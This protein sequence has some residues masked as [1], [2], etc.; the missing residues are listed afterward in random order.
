MSGNGDPVGGIRLRSTRIDLIQLR[1]CHFVATRLN[2][3][4]RSGGREFH[5]PSRSSSAY[6]KRS[7]ARGLGANGGSSPL[8]EACVERDESV[9]DAAPTFAES[10]AEEDPCRSPQRCA[11][12]GDYRRPNI[13]ATNLVVQGLN[14]DLGAGATRSGGRRWSHDLDGTPPSAAH[15]RI[16]SHRNRQDDA[17]KQSWSRPRPTHLLLSRATSPAVRRVRR[18]IRR[19]CKRCGFKTDAVRYRGPL[20]PAT[21]SLEESTLKQEDSGVKLVDA[22]RA[23][24]LRA[25]TAITP[26][27]PNSWPLS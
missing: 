5:A 4:R 8:V 3:G 10:F 1:C 25:A 9:I 20:D 7:Q 14:G 19:A 15:R 2:S 18:R 24:D 26:A 12:R 22:S 11:K 21:S 16:R 13:G 17:P 23:D 6:L 27:M